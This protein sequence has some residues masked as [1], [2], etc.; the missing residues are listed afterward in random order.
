MPNTRD[1]EMEARSKFNERIV[2]RTRQIREDSPYSREEL[3][4]LIGCSY[5]AMQRYEDRTPLPHYF[6]VKFCEVTGMD[7][8]YV[9]TGRPPES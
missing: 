4:D 5:S 2:T 6:L 1:K 8:R 3:A 7:V 9:L